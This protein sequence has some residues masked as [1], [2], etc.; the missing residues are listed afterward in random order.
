MYAF[1]SGKEVSL[2]QKLLRRGDGGRRERRQGSHDRAHRRQ[3]SHTRAHLAAG[4]HDVIPAPPYG[5]QAGFPAGPFLGGGDS[6]PPQKKNQLLPP[7][8]FTDFI[9]IHPEPPTPRLLPPPQSPS[10]P[11]QKVKS[12]RKPCQG[13]FIAQKIKK[14]YTSIVHFLKEELLFCYIKTYIRK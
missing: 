6:P 13:L 2:V 12:C 7:K 4:S 9:F 11:P 1:G 3:G 10:T 8:I 14:R 5:S